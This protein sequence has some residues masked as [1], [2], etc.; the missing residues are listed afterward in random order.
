M[1]KMFDYVRT[2]AFVFI[3]LR[4]VVYMV[5]YSIRGVKAVS[6]WAKNHRQRVQESKK[7]R[8]QRRSQH[9]FIA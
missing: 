1:K 6:R 4:A 9:I 7:N 5:H 3:L 2:I 8:N